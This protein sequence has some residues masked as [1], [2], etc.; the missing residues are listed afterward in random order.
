MA[1]LH[2]LTTSVTLC[3]EV[4]QRREP[5]F[6]ASSEYQRL[7]TTTPFGCCMLHCWRV[8]FFER[9][10]ECMPASTQLSARYFSVNSKLQA[11]IVPH[12]FACVAPRTKEPFLGSAGRQCNV[13]LV[14]GAIAS[15]TSPPLARLFQLRQTLQ[16]ARL[17]QSF[18]SCGSVSKVQ[19]FD[20]DQPQ[21][22]F[23]L[24]AVA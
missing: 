2:C 12:C 10:S 22:R 16:S 14:G 9:L 20:S 23:V 11:P 18:V 19:A 6:L 24:H 3:G 15:R 13:S 17:R 21:P 8:S 7:V 5:G 1:H 4:W